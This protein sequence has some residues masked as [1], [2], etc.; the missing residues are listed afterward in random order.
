LKMNADVG[1]MK[2]AHPASYKSFDAF[3]A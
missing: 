3:A 1:L 2:P